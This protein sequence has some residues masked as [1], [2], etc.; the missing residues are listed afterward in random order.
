[1]TF[2]IRRRFQQLWYDGN[3]WTCCIADAWKF[4]TRGDADGV[5]SGLAALG[6]LVESVDGE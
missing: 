1:M 3:G 2:V 6:C 4:E 5:I